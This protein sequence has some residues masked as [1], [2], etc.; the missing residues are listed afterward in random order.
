MEV[1]VFK[2]PSNFDTSDHLLND[3]FVNRFLLYL[4]D[5]ASCFCL[6]DFDAISE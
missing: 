3:T 4:C 6:I 5:F 1:V 2:I